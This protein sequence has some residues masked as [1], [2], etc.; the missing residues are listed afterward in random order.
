M[1]QGSF[2]RPPA[3]RSGSPLRAWLLLLCFV[4]PA[5][6][7]RAQDDPVRAWWLRFEDPKLSALTGRALDANNALA[8]SALGVKRARLAAELAGSW[9]GW[10]AGGSLGAH[11][12]AQQQGG[13]VSHTRRFGIDGS[14]AYSV[15]LWGKAGSQRDIAAWE[16]EASEADRQKAAIDLTAQVAL[17]YWRI[18]LANE[19][20]A[21][22]RQALS[23]AGQLASLARARHLAGAVAGL[24]AAQAELNVV[25]QQIDLARLQESRAQSARALDHLLDREPGD[26]SVDESITLRGL[27]VPALPAISLAEGIAGRPDMQALE[28]RLRAALANVA[29]RR[30]DL[31][32]EFILTSSLG[33]AGTTLATMLQNPVGTLVS[34]LTLP[35]FNW[36]AGRNQIAQA[37]IDCEIAALD[38]RDQMLV[39]LRELADAVSASDRLRLELAQ[40]ENALTLARRDEALSKARFR[41]GATGVQPWIDAQGRLRGAE[42]ARAQTVSEQLGNRVSIWQALAADSRAAPVVPDGPQ[43]SAAGCSR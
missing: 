28:L 15:D 31:Y 24:D 14:L 35:L 36:N 21:A 3:F 29:I 30:A 16:A 43:K 7:A 34:Q 33:S 22:S 9:P 13:S 5:G 11:S 17:L 27:T 37:R 41:I 8:Q 2:S 4:L 1:H 32:P 20:M 10:Q 38:F 40:R 12:A 23:E 19:Q 25:N 26:G 6:I 18:G 42:L 39:A